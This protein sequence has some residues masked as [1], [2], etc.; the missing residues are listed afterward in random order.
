M[1]DNGRQPHRA[2]A[3]PHGSEKDGGTSANRRFRR[4]LMLGVGALVGNAALAGRLWQLQVVETDRYRDQATRNRL[5]I[6]PVRP[7]RGLIY[8]RN[9]EPLTRNVPVFGVWVTPADVP[10]AHEA[11]LISTLAALTGERPADLQFRLDIARR[12][13]GRPAR[14]A[15]DVP[16]DSALVIAERR[17]DLPGVQVRADV[18]RKY[19]H[20][21]AFGHL[22]GFVGPVPAESVEEY[23]SQGVGFDEDVG[24]SGI[25]RS[26]QGVLRGVDGSRAVEIDALGGELRKI[27]AE[28]PVEG[29]NVMLTISVREQ[30]AIREIL[31]RHLA[32]RDG[33]AGVV[34]VVRP[35][36]GSIVALVS[37]P[38]YDNNTFGTGGDPDELK[39]LITDPRRPLIN[40][41]I[42][43][44]YPPGSSYKVIAA[45]AALETGVVL[46]QTKIL[47]EGKLVLPSGWAF[48]DWLPSGHGLVDLHRG[49]SESCNIYF[50]NVSGGNPHTNLTG[51]G[52]R[53]MVEFE[54]GFGFG[55]TSGI[56]LPG[57]AAGLVP[58]EEWKRSNLGQ[59][60]VTGDTYHAAIGQGLVQVT[61]LQIAMMYS[62]I[63]NG[64]RLLRPRLVDR[65]ID[66]Q[67]NVLQRPPVRER[68]R[69]PI[70]AEHLQLLRNALLEAV[71]GPNGTG[72]RARSEATIVAGKTG[73]AE[74]SG[75]RDAA[76][77]LPSHAW[78]AG[79][80]P[81]DKPEYGFAV[82][83]RDGG[84][85]SF[86]A[87]PVAR[88]IIDYL[89]TGRMP[90]L[91]QDRPDFVPPMRRLV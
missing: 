51:F 73:T 76:G 63:G 18:H 89:M 14:L 46:P 19:L 79:Y 53:R 81:A 85:G 45:A 25:E 74:Y 75:A 41:A 38:D 59:P 52:N 22:L 32:L 15:P 40:H 26:F 82:L 11:S 12:D 80:A 66:S 23:Q 64:G 77:N 21:D 37:L 68:G 2:L 71:N 57:E 84:E 9:H 48:N 88:D 16:R 60:W 78:F 34:V 43:G 35:N 65:L 7:V 72:R 4:G 13:P 54:H 55:K 67:G 10:K 90:P 87:A 58:T 91:P 5:R 50:Y 17:N 61:P 83:V 62:A 8:D 24:L 28:A 39:R 49:I 3:P 33:G 42:A 56:D 1:P 69:L 29:G 86:A 31:A 44:L 70:S 6:D 30:R 47:C 27:S 36:D 20:G